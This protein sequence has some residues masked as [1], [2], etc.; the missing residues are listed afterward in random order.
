MA[1]TIEDI[2]IDYE[3]DNIKIIKEL[4]RKILTRGSW[5]TV[6]FLFEDYDRSKQQYNPPKVSIRRY[7]KSG[8]T[9]R[10]Q[11]KFNISNKVQA[12]KISQAI[13]EWYP[14]DEE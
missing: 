1:E 6:L 10:M 9:Y 13:T 3:E 8:G 2:S 14:E 4:D 7:R 12:L 5:A 11:N